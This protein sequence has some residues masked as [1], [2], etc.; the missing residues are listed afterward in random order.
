MRKK[1][2]SLLQRV[3]LFDGAKT[4]S[5]SAFENSKSLKSVQTVLSF[6]KS[7]SI[8]KDNVIE[9]PKSITVISKKL[10]KDCSLQK[11]EI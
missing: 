4:I 8:D 6:D 10:F 7:N 5:E 11:I 2:H 1:Q 9:I 3:C